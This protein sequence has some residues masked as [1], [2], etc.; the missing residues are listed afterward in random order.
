MQGRL[1]GDQF[2]SAIKAS[3][4]VGIR[5]EYPRTKIAR[6][7]GHRSSDDIGRVSQ[8]AELSGRSGLAVVEDEYLAKV[9]TQQPGQSGLPAAVTPC[10]GDHP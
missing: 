3:E 2:E 6:G 10:L 1:D 5:R 9:R 8:P 4:V 7:H